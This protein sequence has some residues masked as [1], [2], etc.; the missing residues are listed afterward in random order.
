MSSTA[1]GIESEAKTIVH[2]VHRLLLQ[3]FHG[4]GW[5]KQ[6][7]HRCQAVAETRF[8]L[9]ICHPDL[10]SSIVLEPLHRLFSNTIS[11]AIFS[12]RACRIESFFNSG[13][14]FSREKND[15]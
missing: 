6:Q 5:C 14:K 4:E 13:S 2:R 11:R 8:T 3:I 1:G 12:I 9:R 7:Q 15:P 10:P